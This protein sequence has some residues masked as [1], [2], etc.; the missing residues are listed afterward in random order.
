MG[1][2]RFWVRELSVQFSTCLN[3]RCLLYTHSS[4]DVKQ[5]A[6]YELGV[7]ER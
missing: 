6:G 4:K 1:W 5:V 2:S 3:L 7:Q